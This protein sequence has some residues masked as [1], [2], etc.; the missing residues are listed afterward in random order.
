MKTIV[1]TC[2]LISALFSLRAAADPSGPQTFTG[3]VL[4]TTNAA[5]YTYVLVDTGKVKNWA[6]APQFGVT[7]G[8]TVTITD[9]RPMP[10]Y[11]S[12]TMNRDF[13]VIYFTGKAVVGGATGT[14]AGLPNLPKGHPPVAGTS[15]AGVELPKGHPPI[16]A[17][18]RTTVDLS[19][20]KAVKD[21]QTVATINTDRAKLAGRPVSVRGKVVKYN[22]GVMGKNWLH[23]RDG[24]GSEGGNDLTITTATDA[25]V[26]DTVLVS[27]KVVIDRDFGSGYKYSV[28]IE[29]ADVVV[30]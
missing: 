5:T 29:D 2:C 7:V 16:G 6:A 25:K 11:H 4:E 9:G 24:S 27:G 13:E 10:G 15:Q 18:S 20:I 30:E 19:D 22:A 3:K 12:K 21:G 23:I 28:I 8:D 26:G 1:L 14:T 17:A